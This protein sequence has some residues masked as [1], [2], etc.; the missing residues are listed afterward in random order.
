MHA[1]EY[2]CT[3]IYMPGSALELWCTCARLSASAHANEHET[4]NGMG[5]IQKLAKQR[6]ET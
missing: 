5:S 1:Y 3:Y 2:V 6:T 4:G